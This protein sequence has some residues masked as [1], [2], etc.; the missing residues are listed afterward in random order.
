MKKSIFTL[1]ALFA[2]SLSVYSQ[3][4]ITKKSGE[5]IEAK[6]LEVNVDNIKFKKFNNLDGPIFTVLKS[7][8][9]LIRY[10]NGTKDI[11]NIIE[12]KK[13]NKISNSDDMRFQGMRDSRL[14]YR[15]NNAGMVWTVGTTLILSPVIGVIPAVVHSSIE[16]S[17]YRLNYPDAELKKDS[18]YNN[19]YLEQARRTKKEKVWTAFGV[20]S[21]VWFF[22]IF[23]I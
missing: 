18:E 1:F 11:F 13:A 14:N 12:E 8:V 4:I 5:D 9:L 17:S 10:S 19:A 3:D 7:E 22:V 2:I 15:G 21:V 20:S 6:V 23:I 16:P